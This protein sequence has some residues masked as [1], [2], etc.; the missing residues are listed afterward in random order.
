MAAAVA[1]GAPSVGV[2][3]SQSPAALFGAGASLCVTDFADA[4]LEEALA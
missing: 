1:A 4:R 2:T 3:T